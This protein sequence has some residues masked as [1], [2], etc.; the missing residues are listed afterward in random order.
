[1]KHITLKG[2]WY[3]LWYS[4]GTQLRYE[5]K[6]LLKILRQILSNPHKQKH[7]WW[8]LWSI[9]RRG[10][11]YITLRWL[12]RMA[13]RF[14]SSISLE[15][16]EE[17]KGVAR[18]AGVSFIDIVVINTYDDLLYLA[19]CSSVC[20]IT[21]DQQIIHGRNL[22]YYYPQLLGKDIY[23]CYQDLWIVSISFPWYI[24]CL[25]A[26]NKCGLS[27]SAH[28]SVCGDVS[29]W[30]PTGLMYRTILQYATTLSQSRDIL[31]HL[32]KTVWNNLLVSSSNEKKAFVAEISPQI[33]CF[34]EL[35]NNALR[36]VNHYTD[37]WLLTKQKKAA[38][39]SL[40]RDWYL[41][42]YFSDVLVVWSLVGLDDIKNILCYDDHNRYGRTSIANWWTIQSVV[43]DMS[44]NTLHYA[45]HDELPV[46]KGSRITT[47]ILW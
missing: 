4:H 8:I 33:V 23:M 32:P 36:C 1:M 3:D 44:N 6:E 25:T 10:V 2:R 41:Q 39:G 43:F 31:T 16:L 14:L 40:T 7:V 38:I 9:Y 45:V 46:S 34:R 37:T 47:Y 11:G 20:V 35:T 17:M 19:G 27:L 21:P 30:L 5:I 26:T 42:K 24:W 15:Y 13:R 29:R 18:G 12:R 22:D 28:T